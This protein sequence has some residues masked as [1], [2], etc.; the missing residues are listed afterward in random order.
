[1]ITRL[2]QR[3]M[4]KSIAVFGL[5][6]FTVLLLSTTAWAA[7]FKKVP[8][9]FYRLLNFGLMVGILYYFLRKPL[10]QFFAKR[11]ENI[12]KTLNELETKKQDADQKYKE[13]S[14]K[15]AQL[16]KE[17]DRILQEYI[18]Q[19]EREKVKIIAN[20]EKAAAEIRKMTELAIQQEIKSAKGDLQR[21]IAELSVAAA[22]QMLKDKIEEEDQQRLVNDFMTKV[23][24]AK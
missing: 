21:E 8:D 7:E 22:E 16:D 12:T 2:K 15:L 4:Y 3:R 5:C 13:Y 23:V 17:T 11:T 6:V 10:R 9:F 18:E 20:A 1:M 14:E 19:G 24:E